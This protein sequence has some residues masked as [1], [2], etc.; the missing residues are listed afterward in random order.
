MTSSQM[1]AV[2]LFQVLNVLLVMFDQLPS[3]Y[4][5][6]IFIPRLFIVGDLWICLRSNTMSNKYYGRWLY[7]VQD[8]KKHGKENGNVVA[9]TT[10][11]TLVTLFSKDWLRTCLLP[12]TQQA[13]EQFVINRYILWLSAFI[14]ILD[15][16][17]YV[18][19][20][21]MIKYRMTWLIEKGCNDDNL[22]FVDSQEII[23]FA[24]SLRIV[25][26]KI[27]WGDNINEEII[28]KVS[29][30]RLI[31]IYQMID[32]HLNV[33]FRGCFNQISIKEELSL[34]AS[35]HLLRVLSML[36]HFYHR[37]YHDKEIVWWLAFKTE[38]ERFIQNH[39]SEK[40]EE[41]LEY[42]ERYYYDVIK[43]EI[44]D[45]RCMP[46][47]SETFLPLLIPQNFE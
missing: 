5:P 25:R 19:Y 38:K 23:L 31:E 15:V 39:C 21:L 17:I 11:G 35:Y 33:R 42:I 3:T 16:I 1:E 20:F 10:L 22:D 29:N 13:L 43:Q 6:L 30:T 14:I 4:Y 24:K 28:R 44:D 8:Y 27:F 2:F 7:N 46:F 12:P 9:V 36:L 37:H 45:R 40:N 26:K 18:C 32:F 34:F 41:Y 47:S